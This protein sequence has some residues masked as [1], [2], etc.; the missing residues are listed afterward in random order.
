MSMSIIK[1]LLIDGLLFLGVMTLVAGGF[2]G[3]FAFHASFFWMLIFGLV[4][5]PALFSS[6]YYLGKDVN[7]A[8]HKLLLE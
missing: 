5:I 3:L 2:W 6:S 4:M 1:K 8:A 7:E